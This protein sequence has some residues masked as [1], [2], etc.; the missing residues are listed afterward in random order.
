MT[1]TLTSTL[2]IP[3]CHWWQVICKIG[4]AVTNAAGWAF[5]FLIGIVYDIVTFIVTEAVKA[6]IKTVG[7]LWMRVP[8]PAVADDQYHPKPVIE[9]MQ[10]RI[11]WLA[12]AL[13][14]LSVIVAGMRMAWTMRGQ[15]VREAGKSLLMFMI[16]SVIGVGMISV[17]TRIGDDFAQWVIDDPG[18]GMSFNER[19]DKAFD[20]DFPGKLIFVLFLGLAAIISSVIQIGLMFVRNG[21]VILLCGVLP[22]AAAATNTEMGKAWFRK[23][24]GWL[25]AFLAYKPLAA[26]IYGAAVRMMGTEGDW[27]S[28]ATG[29]AMMVMAVVALPALLRFVSPNTGG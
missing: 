23:I 20:A 15:P 25:A 16:V 19:I 29:I 7:T 18:G 3:M 14:T 26:L 6:I 27:M 5:G 9:F 2:L 21:M 17:L 4:E 1:A 10:G 13:A 24:V 8:N 22:L 28:A 12:L 11:M